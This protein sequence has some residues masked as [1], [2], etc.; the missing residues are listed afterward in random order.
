MSPKS[1]QTWLTQTSIFTGTT[2][3]D[4]T[5]PDNDSNVPMF[6]NKVGSLVFVS[7]KITVLENAVVFK[8]VNRLQRILFF[9]GI[10]TAG[11]KAKYPN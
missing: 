1:Q 8:I 6:M 9:A 3:K 5:A 7:Q 11:P 4:N 10:V 2:A